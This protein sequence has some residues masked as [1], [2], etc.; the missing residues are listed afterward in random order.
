MMP[1]FSLCLQ[2]ETVIDF[3]GWLQALRSWNHQYAKETFDSGI[4]SRKTSH[5]IRIK[6]SAVSLSLSRFFFSQLTVCYLIDTVST[7]FYRVTTK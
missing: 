7:L 1:L 3:S 2:A 6:K 4:V 5:Q